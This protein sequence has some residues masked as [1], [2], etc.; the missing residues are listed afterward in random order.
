[1]FC[2]SVLLYS[3]LTEIARYYSEFIVIVSKKINQ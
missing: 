2:L 3:Q 1:M